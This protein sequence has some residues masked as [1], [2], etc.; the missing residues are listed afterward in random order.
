MPSIQN[1][2]LTRWLGQKRRDWISG[3]QCL[4]DQRDV[5]F[6]T[7]PTFKKPQHDIPPL[8][9]QNRPTHKHRRPQCRRLAIPALPRH[10]CCGALSKAMLLNSPA[11][12][13]RIFLALYIK[14]S[15]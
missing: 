7:T 13:L 12:F 10:P 5:L 15:D 8:P 1:L 14:I 6:E 9:A 4:F 3:I 2:S 11:D